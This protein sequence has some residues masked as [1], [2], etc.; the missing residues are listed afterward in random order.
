MQDI[1][2]AQLTIGLLAFFATVWSII[3][4]LQQNELNTDLGILLILIQFI[5]LLILSFII[6]AILQWINIYDLKTNS[7]ITLI[8]LVTIPLISQTI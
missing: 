8:V 5:V 6:I 1:T 2:K 3:E 4:Q 7:I